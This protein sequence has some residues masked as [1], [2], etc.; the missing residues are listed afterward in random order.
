MRDEIINKPIETLKLAIPSGIYTFQNNL[1]F[2]ALSNLDATTYQVI[3]ACVICRNASTQEFSM[4]T[5]SIVLRHLI[6]TWDV[7]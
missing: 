6:S 4:V 2:I 7:V 5:T 1:A 3:C